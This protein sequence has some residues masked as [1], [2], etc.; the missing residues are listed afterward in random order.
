MVLTGRTGLLALLC[1][2]PIVVSP[3]PETTFVALLGLL[4]VAVIV[5]I[6][7]AAGPMQLDYSRSPDGSVRLG[8]TATAV[9]SVRNLSL[10]HI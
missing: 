1:V 3:W 8:E 7:V 4:L 5:D 6:A 10:I 9:L 2:L